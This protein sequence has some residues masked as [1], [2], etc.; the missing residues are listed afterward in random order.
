M[1]M[2]KAVSM[3]A[4]AGLIYSAPAMAEE[5][6]NKMPDLYGSQAVKS[7][8]WTNKDK[9][10]LGKV[11]HLHKGGTCAYQIA[12]NYCNGKLAEKPFAVYNFKENKL[13]IDNKTAEGTPGSDGVID[14][15]V[16]HPSGRKVA[17]DAPECD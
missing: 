12:F 4:L 17:D 7:G 10:K 9:T 15:I 3:V 5:I 6:G 1:E 14:D 11:D 16:T 8:M 2:K 13:Y